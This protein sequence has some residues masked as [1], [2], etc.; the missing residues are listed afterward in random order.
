LLWVLHWAGLH[1]A[2]GISCIY[3]TDFLLRNH[4]T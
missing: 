1:N 3:F 4:E 2:A